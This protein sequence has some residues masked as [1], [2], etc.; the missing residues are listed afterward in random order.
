MCS[1]WRY[2]RRAFTESD[3]TFRENDCLILSIFAKGNEK[4]REE[5]LRDAIRSSKQMTICKSKVR[6]TLLSKDSKSTGME[7]KRTPRCVPACFMN[8]TSRATVAGRRFWV[9]RSKARAH[10]ELSC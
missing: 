5:V 10:P 9:T 4:T 2:Y 6:P 3:R 1:I 7:R 8:S